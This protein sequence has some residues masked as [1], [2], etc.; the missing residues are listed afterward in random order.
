MT[1]EK[2]RLGIIGGGLMGR[3]AA[4]AFG[5]WFVLQDFP[6]DVELTAVCDLQPKLLDWFRGVPTVKLI[7]EDHRE[8]LRSPD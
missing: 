8:L 1:K 6:V 2:M 3:E 7:T 5:R 4:S